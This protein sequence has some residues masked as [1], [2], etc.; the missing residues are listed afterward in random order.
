MAFGMVS[1]RV[2]GE[3]ACFSRPEFKVERVSYPMMTPSAARGV[4]EAIFWRPEIRYEIRRIGV[5]KPGRDTVILRNEIDVRQGRD[6]LV[7]EERRVQRSSLV[8]RDVEYI[9]QAAV[10]LR[11][12]A[13]D[14]V[15]KYIEQIE[16]RIKR[17]QFHHTPYLGTRECSCSFSVW[18]GEQPDKAIRMVIGTILFEIAYVPSA[19]R[20]EMT[21]RVPGIAEPVA[22]YA[23][24]LYLEDARLVD[25][26]LHVPPGRYNDLYRLEAGN[27]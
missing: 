17:G 15:A 14:P 19:H 8:L 24:A 5:L 18:T 1:L 16:R 23:H 3:L 26:W 25:G 20:G 9:I 4:L 27:V 11:S 12:H 2:W 6:P 22:G 21:F 13:T 7:V 10:I